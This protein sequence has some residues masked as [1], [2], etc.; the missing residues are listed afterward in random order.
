[1]KGLNS[2]ISDRATCCDGTL[3]DVEGIFWLNARSVLS[4]WTTI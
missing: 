4:F 3:F 1:M 2:E